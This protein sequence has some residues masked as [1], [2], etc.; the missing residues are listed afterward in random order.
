[1]LHA[2]AFT[3]TLVQPHTVTLRTKAG[4]LRGRLVRGA[5]VFPR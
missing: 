4:I 5:I 3:L 1:M 2:P